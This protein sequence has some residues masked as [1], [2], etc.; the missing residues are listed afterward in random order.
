M[1]GQ[2][3]QLVVS[4][5]GLKLANLSKV[6][7]ARSIDRV[8]VV[9][10]PTGFA[11]GGIAGVA[12]ASAL[13]AEPGGSGLTFQFALAGGESA[14]T[15]SA[16][17]YSALVS[18]GYSFA[19]EAGLSGFTQALVVAASSV[20]PDG[21]SFIGATGSPV[22]IGENIART[23]DTIDLRN[24]E[25]FADLPLFG[26]V[27]S[28][29]ISSFALSPKVGTRPTIVS[30]GGWSAIKTLSNLNGTVKVNLSAEEF[31]EIARRNGLGKNDDSAINI[32]VN[33]T[34]SILVGAARTPLAQSVN[35]DD[36]QPVE[37]PL[38]LATSIN[39][40]LNGAA[41]ATTPT[42]NVDV[43]NESSVP[44]SAKVIGVTT[45]NNYTTSAGGDVYHPAH[46][47]WLSRYSGFVSGAGQ[48]WEAI[49][50]L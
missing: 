48:S 38:S 6:V 4:L 22:Q 43:L 8:L 19:S 5:A 15:L 20:Q 47:K 11:Q 27:E 18:S 41:T 34:N 42:A 44:T 16:P 23:L 30:D 36:L 3:Q 25:S 39:N 13:K 32:K 17:V 31:Q 50:E 21:T 46:G 33:D 1:A 28:G 37:L 7:T 9:D 49:G 40:I 45:I 14:L 10:T 26:G 24:K 12:S 35:S 29:V 2:Q